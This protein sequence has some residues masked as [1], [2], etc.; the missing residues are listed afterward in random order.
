MQKQLKIGL[1]GVGVVGSAVAKILRQNKDIITA[2]TGVEII[3][4]KGIVKNL[5]KHKDAII[6]LSDNADEVLYD[7]EIDVIVELM[8]GVE[9]AY[10]IAKIA[11]SQHKAFVTANKAMLAYHRYELEQL[12]KTPIGFEASVCGG[13]PIIKA[14]KEGLSANHILAI[15]GILNGTSNYIL[16]KMC[17]EGWDFARALKQA[18]NLGYAE[19]DP[20]LDINGTDAAHKLLILASLA[21]GIDS[22]PEEILIEGIE[23]LAKEDIE[24]AREFGYTIKLLGIAK[25]R[26]EQIELRIHPVMI[27]SQMLLAKVDGVMNA[28]SV[29]GDSVGESV[30]YGAGAGGEATAS[31]VISDLIQ[32]ARGKIT[33]ENDENASQ[34]TRENMRG[35]MLGFHISQPLSIIPKEQILS[36]YYVR[37]LAIDTYGV[38]EKI[39]S[40]LSRNHISISTFLQKPSDDGEN[41][42]E[43]FAKADFDNQN[44]KNNKNQKAKILLS[45][46]TTTESAI[47]NAIIELEALEVVLSKPIIIRIEE[48]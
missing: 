3:I 43:N 8:G 33:Q 29:V 36:S 48:A 17:N 18:Q 45:T 31:S 5:S 10:N 20:T 14:L 35:N 28:I 21:Y 38:L 4:K 2:R 34:N 16:S 1:I 30:Y 42:G 39:A 32:I 6:P 23:N 44:V 15:R 47:K 22:R 9:Y 26:G 25:K 27:N 7:N 24:F 13:I 19:A 41:F 11:L 40:V 46:H 37:I 12:A